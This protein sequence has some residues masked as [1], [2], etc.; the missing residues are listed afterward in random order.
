MYGGQVRSQYRQDE[1]GRFLIPFRRHDGDVR[2]YACHVPGIDPVTGALLPWQ[3]AQA[4][5]DGDDLYHVTGLSPSAFQSQSAG[6]PGRLP[7]TRRVIVETSTFLREYVFGN[8]VRQSRWR[9]TSRR[10]KKA[11]HTAECRPSC[12]KQHRA[13]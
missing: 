7:G 3:I 5:L 12:R 2:E 1:D 9:R 8:M 4:F 10:Q 11:R 6:F 13:G